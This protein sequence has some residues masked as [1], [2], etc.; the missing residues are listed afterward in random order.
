MK[1]KLIVLLSILVVLLIGCGGTGIPDEAIDIRVEMD[2]AGVADSWEWATIPPTAY[3]ASEAPGPVGLPDHVEIA[4][5]GTAPA[6]RGPGEPVI[7]VIPIDD[8]EQLWNDAGDSTITDRLAQLRDIIASG[9]V[10]S[11]GIQALPVEEASAFNDLAVQG[12][13]TQLGEW[14]GFRFV[15]RYEQS[16]NP[17]TNQNLRYIFQGFSPN[18]EYLI[19]VFYPV[20]AGDALPAT[21]ADVPADVMGRVETDNQAYMQEQIDALNAL[22]PG[23]WSPD[24][25]ALDSMVASVRYIGDES[26]PAG[27]NE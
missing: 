15:G 17:V 3:N 27:G 11:S 19:A 25:A 9:E 14:N 18:G 2:T 20:S 13:V 1:Y 10:P 24:L 7:Y 5:N 8:Y 22:A 23:D 6:D 21:A 26:G 12:V 4:F 16:A